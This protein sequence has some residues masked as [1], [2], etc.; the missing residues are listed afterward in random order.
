MDKTNRRKRAQEKVRVRDI[1]SFTHSGIILKALNWKAEHLVQTMSSPAFSASASVTSNELSYGYLERLVSS[2]SSFPSG[3]HTLCGHPLKEG[4][5][6]Y[7]IEIII[8]KFSSSMHNVWLCVFIF[9]PSCCRRKPIWWWMG[10]QG[11]NLCVY[12]KA[13]LSI[14]LVLFF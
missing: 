13:I 6:E 10:E 12:Q 7:P 5:D 14:H 1:H 4:C 8:S 11:R 2:L 9:I 3:S